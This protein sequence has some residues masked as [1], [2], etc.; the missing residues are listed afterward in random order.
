MMKYLSASYRVD[1]NIFIN[2]LVV[3]AT[4]ACI[5]FANTKCRINFYN[6]Q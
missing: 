5:Q 4:A 6:L 2:L 1:G 3:M